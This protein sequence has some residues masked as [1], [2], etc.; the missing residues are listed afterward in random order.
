MTTIGRTRGIPAAGVQVNQA[1]RH[2]ASLEARGWTRQR[3]AKDAGVAPSTITKLMNAQS[4]HFARSTVVA[5][6]SVGR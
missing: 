6:L 5:I 2:V 3:I 1:R 4:P